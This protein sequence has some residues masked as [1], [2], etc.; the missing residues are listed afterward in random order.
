MDDIN[1]AKELTIVGYSINIVPD[2][3]SKLVKNDCNLNNKSLN[4]YL[5]SIIFLIFYPAI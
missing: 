5:F 2:N 1:R 4:I 3:I